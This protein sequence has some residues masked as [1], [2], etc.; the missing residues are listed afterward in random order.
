[1]PS[2]IKSP[3]TSDF[4]CWQILLQKSEMTQ[5]PLS[6]RKTKKATIAGRYSL[7]PH[8]RVDVVL[9]KEA[10]SVG[11]LF[12]SVVLSRVG[13]YPMVTRWRSRHRHWQRGR[14]DARERWRGPSIDGVPPQSVV[15][16]DS[17][18]CHVREGRPWGR[19]FEWSRTEA[20]LLSFRFL[21]EREALKLVRKRCPTP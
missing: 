17:R 12:H 6:R 7:K 1:M 2:E 16:R 21:D 9:H 10:A 8:T 20:A 14:G 15:S 19:D 3:A 13:Q 18:F 5:R 4:R 11:G